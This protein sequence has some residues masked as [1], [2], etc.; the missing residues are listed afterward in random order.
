MMKEHRNTPPGPPLDCL[1]PTPTQN[2]LCIKSRVIFYTV[3]LILGLVEGGPMPPCSG[4][5][6]V[7]RLER[8][9]QELGVNTK[10][11]V[12]ELIIQTFK[13]I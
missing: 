11:K 6:Y 12:S 4:L 7:L 5:C 2:T 13:I 10:E 3:C 9:L 1:H 8:M